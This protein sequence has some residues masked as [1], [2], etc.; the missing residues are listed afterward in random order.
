MV[1]AYSIRGRFLKISASM[2]LNVLEIVERNGTNTLRSKSIEAFQQ[3]VSH[4][5]DARG[6][7]AFGKNILGRVQSAND[8]CLA[9]ND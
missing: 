2:L 1:L 6:V 8:I 7:K 4:L 3:I 5:C 9:F